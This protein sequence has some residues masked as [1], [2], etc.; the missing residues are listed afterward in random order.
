MLNKEKVL[1]YMEKHSDLEGIY[2]GSYGSIAKGLKVKHASSI[3]NMMVQL[4][5]EG[6][7]KVLVE[8]QRGRN[9]AQYLVVRDNEDYKDVE[10]IIV[11]FKGV[12]IKM[13]LS[14]IGYVISKKQLA[15]ATDGYTELIDLKVQ[16]NEE[17][18]K[19]NMTVINGEQYFNKFAIMFYLNKLDLSMMRDEK[20]QH[21]N[22]F[23]TLIVNKMCDM[24]V[25]GRATLTQDNKIQIESNICSLCEINQEQIQDL[26]GNIEEQVNLLFAKT[27]KE[28]EGLKKDLNNTN[29]LLEKQVE[30]THSYQTQLRESRLGN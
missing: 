17:Q 7:I 25:K 28:N 30:L 5:Y 19:S 26:L 12:T 11:E 23:Q 4:I 15:M 22:E 8:P 29:N 10:E 16:N 1:N 6:K 2:S 21:L 20:R 18:F 27:K 14:D 13:I 3:R 24:V 9:E